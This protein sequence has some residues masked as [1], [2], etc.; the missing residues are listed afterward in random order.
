MRFLVLFIM[1][2]TWNTQNTAEAKVA[3]EPTDI[4]RVLKRCKA[5]HGKDLRGKKKAPSLYD[6]GFSDVYVSLTS[7]VPKKM[8]R[9][10]KKLTEAE[11]WEVSRFVSELGVTNDDAEKD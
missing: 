8:E 6:K 1:L 2:F 10:V 9:I 4:S 5:C 11:V 3:E 7:D